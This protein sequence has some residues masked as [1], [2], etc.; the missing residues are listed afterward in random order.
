MQMG[1]ICNAMQLDVSSAGEHGDHHS[2]KNELLL[3]HFQDEEAYKQ[4][5]PHQSLLVIQIDQNFVEG[6]TSC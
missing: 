5:D 4:T 3:V 1:R 6:Y 2:L